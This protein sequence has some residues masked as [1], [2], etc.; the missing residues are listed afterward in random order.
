M[1][2]LLNHFS[3]ID[4]E[5]IYS[6]RKIITSKS[7]FLGDFYKPVTISI[8]VEYLEE[9][10]KRQEAEIDKHVRVFLFSLILFTIDKLKE[11]TMS[12]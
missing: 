4:A 9:I 2:I 7:I 5:S 10:V 8:D 11:M 3:G 12:E 1:R 6:F